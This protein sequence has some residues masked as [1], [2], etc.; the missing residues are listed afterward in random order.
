MVAC[1]LCH[2]VCRNSSLHVHPHVHCTTRALCRSTVLMMATSA[3]ASSTS[4]TDAAKAARWAAIKAAYNIRGAT[5]SDSEGLYK[6]CLQTGDSGKDGT[7]LFKDDPDALGKWSEREGTS[8][9]PSPPL[10][11]SPNCAYFYRMLLAIGWV[12]GECLHNHTWSYRQYDTT[13]AAAAAAGSQPPCTDLCTVAVCCPPH[14]RRGQKFCFVLE[15]VETGEV[16]GYTLGTDN[17]TAFF[18]K[19]HSERLHVCMPQPSLTH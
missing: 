4:E 3:A 2:G 6:V 13:R 12:Q 1:Q 19:V 10:N 5:A 7:R 8:S 16:V 15:L 9:P 11:N 14:A 18:D 17:T